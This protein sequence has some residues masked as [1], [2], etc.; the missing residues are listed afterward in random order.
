MEELEDKPDQE[1]KT[2]S[3]KNA[4]DIIIWQNY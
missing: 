1:I 4:P 2:K 3:T